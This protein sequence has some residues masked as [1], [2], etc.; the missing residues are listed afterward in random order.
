MRHAV[1][2]DQYRDHRSLVMKKLVASALA[3][4]SLLVGYAA[5]TTESSDRPATW[6]PRAGFRSPTQSGSLSF[7]LRHPLRSLRAQLFFWS[8]RHRVTL[9]LRQQP[10]GGV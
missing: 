7:R 10:V 5:L 8:L 4:A 1:C 3:L 6:T 9:W 2:A